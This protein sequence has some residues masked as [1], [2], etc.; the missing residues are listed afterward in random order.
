MENGNPQSQAIETELKCRQ[1]GAV[2]QYKPGTSNLR[3]PYCS[4]ENAIEQTAAAIEER[5]FER[6]L[7]EQAEKEEKIE[8]AVVKCPG[9]AATVS[10]RAHVTSDS[11]PYCA[12]SLVLSGGSTSR[13]L[14][15]Q[16]VLPFRIDA[17]RAQT[18]FSDW[19][20]RRWFAPESFRRQSRTP[21]RF[22]GLYVP[23][24]T[25]DADTFSRYSGE[26]G[27]H[28][29]TTETYPA[30]ENGRT[31]MRTR[32]VQ[33]TRWRSVSGSVNRLFDDQ[34]VLASRSLPTRYAERLTPWELK[35]LTPFNE[36]YLSGFQTESYQ[37][38][39][40]EGFATARE[41]MTSAIHA[42]VRSDIGGDEQ[43]VHQVQT[44][45]R[46]ITFKHILLP[47]WISSYRYGQKLYRFLINGCSGEVQGERPWSVFKILLAIAGIGGLITLL[48][49]LFNH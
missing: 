17:G 15:P 19:A 2:L 9:C 36:K 6:F 30:R 23:Y 35:N 5:D 24:W 40:P 12:T 7:A 48:V 46:R 33:H 31:V 4:A 18:L 49:V 11:C 28:Y 22:R 8:T 3:C 39:L 29:F 26:R 42:A 10:L 1:C 43:R 44:D 34:L 32:Q 14:K 45:W 16:G 20:R 41:A 37:V 13:Q 38:D 25:F 47:V 21:D 27:D